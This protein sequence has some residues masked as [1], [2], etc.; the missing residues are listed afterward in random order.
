M[1][2]GRALLGGL[3]EEEAELLQAL[4]ED[5]FA[6]HDDGGWRGEAEGYHDGS[7]LHTAIPA[8]V[9]SPAKF[10]SRSG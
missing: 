7:A 9:D 1:P 10:A 5:V 2:C 8:V 6:G 4:G 3:A